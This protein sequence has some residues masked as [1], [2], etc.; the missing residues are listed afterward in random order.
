MRVIKNPIE[1]HFPPGC[2][3]VGLSVGASKKVDINKYMA[4][5]PKEP[6]AFFVGAFAHGQVDLS[7]CT[8]QICISDF[9]LSA[10]VACGKICCAA[11]AKWGL[12]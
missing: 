9:H 6:V 5:M 11:E 4:T 8:E 10:A 2:R 3:K 12:F 7:E 1:A